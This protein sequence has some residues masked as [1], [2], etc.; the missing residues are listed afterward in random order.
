MNYKTGIWIIALLAVTLLM[1]NC[2]KDTNACP[3]EETFCAYINAQ[4][5]DSTGTII[6]RFLE[7]LSQNAGDE[8][9][10]EL[11]R[12]WLACFKC[13]DNVEILC[14]SCIKTNP[15]QSELKVDF[16]IENQ[17]IELIIDILMDETLKFVRFHD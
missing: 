10:M 1:A 7:K 6:N 2:N 17:T 15:P 9:K 11:L 13:V 8:E 4:S 14:V 5:F 16:I 3:E 12:N